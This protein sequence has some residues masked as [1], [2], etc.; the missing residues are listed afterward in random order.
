M[1]STISTKGQITVPIEVRNKLGLTPGT[2]VEFVLRNSDVVL[3]KGHIGVHPVDRV[4]G[5]V[6]LSAPVDRILDEMRGP[7]PKRRR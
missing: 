6:S 5:V 7:R 1:R 3:K 2:A 4:F